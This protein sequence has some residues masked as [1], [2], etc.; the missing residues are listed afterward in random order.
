[1]RDEET[2]SKKKFCEQTERLKSTEGG[3]ELEER[4]G[5]RRTEWHR[6]GAL[7]STLRASSTINPPTMALVVPMAGMMLPAI[8]G[9][10][11]VEL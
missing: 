1:M 11:V 7:W 10:V 8:A 5:R 2:K 6:W 3:K 9:V 4:W